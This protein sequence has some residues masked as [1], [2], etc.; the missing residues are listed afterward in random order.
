MSK[1][2]AGCPSAVESTCAPL[3]TAPADEAE[4]TDPPITGMHRITSYSTFSNL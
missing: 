4:V 1:T 3:P 2:S